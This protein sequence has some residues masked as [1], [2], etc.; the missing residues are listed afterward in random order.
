MP[1]TSL[2]AE[3]IGRPRFNW[4]ASKNRDW[5]GF[6]ERSAGASLEPGTKI[7]STGSPPAQLCEVLTPP[8]NAGRV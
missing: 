4:P 6:S 7:S 3:V 1:D 2:K 8:S 5:R